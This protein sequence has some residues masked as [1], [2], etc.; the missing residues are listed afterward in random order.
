MID[1]ALYLMLGSD[2][3]VNL[4]FDGISYIAALI[5]SYYNCLQSATGL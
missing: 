3:V 1:T 4:K 5:L 2:S